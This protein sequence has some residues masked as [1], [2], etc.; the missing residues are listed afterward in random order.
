MWLCGQENMLKAFR[1][2]KDPYCITATDH[3]G[4]PVDKSMQQERFFGKMLD[5][6]LGFGMGWR[7]LR[8]NAAVGF[9]GCPAVQLSI[10]EAQGAV[11]GYRASKNHVKEMW[12][13][14]TDCIPAMFNKS[15]NT[16][17]KCIEFR[18]ESIV[19]PNGMSLLYPLLSCV[20][21]GDWLCGIGREQKKIYGGIL[22]ENIVQALA[23]IVVFEQML[24]IDRT[25]GL[26]VVSSTHDEVIALVREQEAKAAVKYM[27]D[28]MSVPPGWAP[29]LPLAAEGGFA[30]EYSK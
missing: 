15:C 2:G 24:E 18:H 6:A 29:D 16:D 28:V 19:L 17:Y 20:E 4:Y 30:C 8:A 27:E 22:D 3:F 11:N 9:M 7:K 13:Y 14:L 21:G 1:A 26:H 25:E 5:L 10:Q 23:R 12:D